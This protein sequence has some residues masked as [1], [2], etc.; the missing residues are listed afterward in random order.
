MLL[1]KWG[2]RKVI[3]G[4]VIPG[5]NTKYIP[6]FISKYDNFRKNGGKQWWAR[7]LSWHSVSHSFVLGGNVVTT[8][9]MIITSWC[10]I[11]IVNCC[12]LSSRFISFYCWHCVLKFWVDRQNMYPSTILS[13]FLRKMWHWER[14]G[15]EIDSE[16]HS[17]K[18]G[19]VCYCDCSSLF[20]VDWGM[21]H[22]QL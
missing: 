10:H 11:I 5:I 20:K 21:L 16:S 7:M 13:K 2:I 22:V 6:Q 1:F 3:P 9:L 15:Q 12:L 8:V 14:H 4:I 17:V 19:F 18:F